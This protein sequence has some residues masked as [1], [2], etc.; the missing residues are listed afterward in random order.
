M[1]C[2]FKN[3]NINNLSKNFITYN[4]KYSLVPGFIVPMILEER[5]HACYY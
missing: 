2:K 3:I 1:I 5:L 4:F